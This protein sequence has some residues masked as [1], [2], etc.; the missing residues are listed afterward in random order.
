[1]EKKK[2]EFCSTEYW[3]P[4]GGHECFSVSNQLLAEGEVAI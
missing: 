2:C 1:M 3:E 4:P